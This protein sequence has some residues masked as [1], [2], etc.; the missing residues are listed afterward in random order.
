ME[1]VPVIIVGG[2]PAGAS[3]AWKL[4]HLGIDCLILE[5]RVFPRNKPCA[6]WIPPR[7]LEDLVFRVDDYP[8]GIAVFETLHAFVHGIRMRIRGPHYAIRRYEFDAWLLRRSEATVRTHTVEAIRRNTQK[9]V[10][11]DQYSCDYLVGAGGT[12]CPVYRILFAASSPRSAGSCVVTLEEEF[13]YD[14]HDDRCQLWFFENKLPG[15]AWYVPKQD[16]YLNV[17]VGGLSEQIKR[18]GSRIRDHWEHL[19]QK[20]QRRGMV[21]DHAFKPRGYV[22]YRRDGEAPSRRGN[23]FVVGDAAGLA[24]RDM[25]EGIGP[26]VRSGILAAQAVADDGP[27]S[28]DCVSKYSAIL[29]LTSGPIGRW[30]LERIS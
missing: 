14:R 15:Y 26:A 18:R 6:G 22:Y 24:T 4:R 23:A 20:L 30:L 17:G 29:P 19:T 25:G 10:I 13:P 3:C 12:H 5:K 21:T 11:D 7:V 8:H 1:H 28:L 27:F 16:G 2:G 9:Y